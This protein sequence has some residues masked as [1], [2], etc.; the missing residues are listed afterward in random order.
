MGVCLPSNGNQFHQQ[1]IFRLSL[2]HHNTN[3]ATQRR[4]NPDRAL[5]QE[6]YT[7]REILYPLYRYVYLRHLVLSAISLAVGRS[8]G[9]SCSHHTNPYMSWMSFFISRRLFPSSRYHPPLDAS[10]FLVNAEREYTKVVELLR[11]GR[12]T[13]FFLR[14]AARGRCVKELR[15]LLDHPKADPS[16][17]NNEALI[18]AHPKVDPTARDNYAIHHASKLG[19][20]EIEKMLLEKR[21]Q[22]MNGCTG[23]DSTRGP[24]EVTIPE[25]AA[26]IEEVRYHEVDPESQTLRSIRKT[27]RLMCQA[28]FNFFVPPGLTHRREGQNEI[29][30]YFRD[31]RHVL[32]ARVTEDS[33]THLP[34]TLARKIA[35]LLMLQVIKCS[36]SRSERSKAVTDLREENQKTWDNLPKVRQIK[37]MKLPW[38]KLGRRS[39]IVVTSVHPFEPTAFSQLPAVEQ[40]PTFGLSLPS[41][42]KPITQS[43]RLKEGSDS[44]EEIN[45]H[46][47]N[48]SVET[49]TFEGTHPSQDPEAQAITEGITSMNLGPKAMKDYEENGI[50]VK[51]SGIASNESLFNMLEKRKLFITA[52]PE[53]RNSL[54]QAVELGLL[55]RSIHS[56]PTLVPWQDGPSVVAPFLHLR[57][58]TLQWVDEELKHQSYGNESL[59]RTLTLL[60]TRV[61]DVPHYQLLTEATA[62]STEGRDIYMTAVTEEFVYRTNNL[63]AWSEHARSWSDNTGILSER[64]LEAMEDSIDTEVFDNNP[65]YSNGQLTT[66]VKIGMIGDSQE[67]KSSLINAI[68]GQE[69]LPTGQGNTS[70]TSITVEMVW[71]PGK[72]FYMEEIMWPPEEWREILRKYRDEEEHFPSIGKKIETVHRGR[73]SKPRPSTIPAD[74][75]LH[76]W[77]K[78]LRPN[79]G[80]TVTRDHLAAE[81]KTAMKW[82]QLKTIRVQGPFPHLPPGVILLDVPGFNDPNYINEEIAAAAL[83][84]CKSF[85][86]TLYRQTKTNIAATKR[87]LNEMGHGDLK[88]VFLALTKIDQFQTGSWDEKIENAKEAGREHIQ[89]YDRPLENITMVPV[90]SK[91]D[92]AKESI[93]AGNFH[94]EMTGI[95][96]MRRLLFGQRFAMMKRDVE[97]K[98]R[99]IA[100][101]IRNDIRGLEGER[102]QVPDIAPRVLE[103]Y[104]QPVVKSLRDI[105]RELSCRWSGI[106]HS[107]WTAIFNKNRRGIFWSSGKAGY[108]N[109]HRETSSIIALRIE[110]F[111]SRCFEE[112]IRQHRDRLLQELPDLNLPFRGADNQIKYFR[113]ERVYE[114]VYR[115]FHEHL[116]SERSAYKCQEYVDDTVVPRNF[117][118]RIQ[119]DRQ[120]SLRFMEEAFLKSSGPTL[121]MCRAL[122]RALDLSIQEI[123][124]L[125]V[126]IEACIRMY[127]MD[128]PT[129]AELNE[130][131]IKKQEYSQLSSDARW[132]A[133]RRHLSDQMSTAGIWQITLTAQPNRALQVLKEFATADPSMYTKSICVRQQDQSGKFRGVDAGGLT[134]EMFTVV[135]QH[136][137]APIAGSP[138][139]HLSLLRLVN[140]NQDTHYF[141]SDTYIRNSVDPDGICLRGLGV[142]IGK[143]LL[144]N[145]PIPLSLSHA[146]YKLFTGRTLSKEDYSDLSGRS[147]YTLEEVLDAQ[148]DYGPIEASYPALTKET[149]TFP[150]TTTSQANRPVDRE[151]YEQWS[152]QAAAYELVDKVRFSA[153][154]VLE[155]LFS[156]IPAEWMAIFT[157]EMIRQ[158][159]EGE[160]EVSAEGLLAVTRISLDLDRG[161]RSDFK[162]VI[163]ELSKEQLV[164]LLHY[165][166]SRSRLP[167]GGQEVIL[168][169]RKGEGKDL[170]PHAHTCSGVLDLPQY[171]SYDKMKEMII[172][173]IEYAG[174]GHQNV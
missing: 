15:L 157:P 114:L 165:T 9:T 169:V 90:C 145:T 99:N 54:Q 119:A 62:L 96:Q 52:S 85:I 105:R 103:L 48:C 97:I 118:Q 123:H 20:K 155:G 61:E 83:K 67:G 109:L 163:R 73:C 129:P 168:S 115:H 75:L 137:Q 88:G 3:F 131:E 26:E 45:R 135:C 171:T 53:G 18:T 120:R 8:F 50:G 38:L 21:R 12:V 71:R 41:L 162:R 94:E 76:E 37:F 161:R 58:N 36:S 134:R 150:M 154:K 49:M 57:I 132:S 44:K 39:I 93:G 104:V 108:V 10:L 32:Q 33:F 5:Y 91:L 30:S 80:R 23:A 101:K 172:T 141:N 173:A 81:I 65:V 110:P 6:K 128:R 149:P 146:A 144:E 122:L 29:C 43:N 106:W 100:Q 17:Q 11:N 72:D 153:G 13:S 63:K 51:E 107:T 2:P 98:A 66:W 35:Q 70:C 125:P 130:G 124:S 25:I 140:P 28:L 60:E 46:I 87:V 152:E 166:T 159:L 86:I 164:K 126:P 113:P 136:V 19:Y 112:E 7:R 170:L 77:M 127:R 82:G 167:V 47:R 24:D 117:H 74:Q 116:R 14:A 68:L 84:E 133:V 64:A 59:G 40:C 78:D 69:I 4:M 34:L 143:A 151:N 42:P 139:G 102:R 147:M 1:E 121:A 89:S 158:R 148:F 27:S 174:E 160:R 156:I 95:P 55:H 79:R 138:E 92:S 31:K 142:M 56:P 16:A 22:R 111:A